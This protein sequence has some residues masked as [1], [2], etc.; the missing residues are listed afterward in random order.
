[1]SKV[2]LNIRMKSVR[3]GFNARHF[4]LEVYQR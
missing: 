3:A 2:D 1:M 4:G